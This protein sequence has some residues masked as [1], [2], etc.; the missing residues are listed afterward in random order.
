MISRDVVA[1]LRRKVHW[2]VSLYTLLGVHKLGR[3]ADGDALHIHGRQPPACS[4]PWPHRISSSVASRRTPLTRIAGN[5]AAGLARVPT[6][7]AGSAAPQT[8]ELQAVLAGSAAVRKHG[9]RLLGTHWADRPGFWLS[10]QL[11]AT[12]HGAAVARERAARAPA[13]GYTANHCAPSPNRLEI[14]LGT[15][16]KKIVRPGASIHGPFQY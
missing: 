13:R 15:G 1:S 9:C 6:R 16:L 11:D 2:S 7:R 14:Q 4:R 5:V 8:A 12:A 3:G 10:T